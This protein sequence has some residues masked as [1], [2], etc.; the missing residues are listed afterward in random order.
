MKYV[1]IKMTSATPRVYAFTFSE[2]L[3]HSE[4]AR[5]VQRA[6]EREFRHPAEVYSA[7]FCETGSMG[8][9]V[10]EHGSESLR[11]NKNEQQGNDDES[12]LNQPSALQDMLL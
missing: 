11:I 9:Y 4:V 7:G 12:I 10:T 6:V 2:R 3:T 5:W 8:F 1:I